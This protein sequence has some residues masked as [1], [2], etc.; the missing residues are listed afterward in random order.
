MNRLKERNRRKMGMSDG[1]KKKKEKKRNIVGTF[2]VY[3]MYEL[4]KQIKLL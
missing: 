1:K 3:I 4:I 2:G